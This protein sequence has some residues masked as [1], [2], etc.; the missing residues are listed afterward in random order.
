MRLPVL[1]IEGYPVTDPSLA[2]I[3]V[4]LGGDGTMLGVALVGEKGVPILGV[5]IE[6]S[7]FSLLFT[8]MS[9]ARFL[10]QVSPESVPWKSGLCLKLV[11]SGIASALQ[12][13]LL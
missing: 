13:T 4:V 11:S 7:D 5:N 1:N 8:R 9:L 6:A 12:N 10:E 2:D 3:I